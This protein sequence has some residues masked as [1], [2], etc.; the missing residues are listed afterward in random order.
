MDWASGCCN[1]FDYVMML[2]VLILKFMNGLGK[3]IM[4]II[5]VPG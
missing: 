4:D 3:E 2:E 1:N 5:C